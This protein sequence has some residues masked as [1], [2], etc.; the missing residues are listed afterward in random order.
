MD[1]IS[2]ICI[3]KRQWKQLL[4]KVCSLEPVVLIGCKDQ[5]TT[6]PIVPEIFSGLKKERKEK[7]GKE[8]G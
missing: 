1:V 8:K 4:K 3:G 2:F 7:K 5:S 6:A